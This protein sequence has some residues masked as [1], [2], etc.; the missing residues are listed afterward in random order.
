MRRRACGPVLGNLVKTT[1]AT[2]AAAT[3]ALAAL[4]LRFGDATRIALD[5]TPLAAAA[6][7]ELGERA[8]G[9]VL[10]AGAMTVRRGSSIRK[11]T[12]EYK[13]AQRNIGHHHKIPGLT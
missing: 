12:R 8:A 10:H 6:R 4:G 13:S 5:L 1:A 2:T 7:A 3:A 9:V 11:H